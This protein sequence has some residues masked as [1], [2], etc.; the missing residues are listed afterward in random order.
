MSDQT[1]ITKIS[2]MKTPELIGILISSIVLC[3]LFI[4]ATR[5][6]SVVQS[7]DQAYFL[8]TIDTTYKTG[9]PTTRLQFSSLLYIHDLI[10][11]PAATVCAYPLEN[12]GQQSLNLYKRHSI[13]QLYVLGVIRRILPS[14]IIYY[15]CALLAFPGLLLVI[16][17]GSRYLRLPI[18]ISV[19]LSLMVA[20]HP[21]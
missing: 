4:N 9:H 8:E 20:F 12:D 14:K 3:F 2:Q 17:L 15:F 18:V 13:P 6:Y 19:I 5:F 10:V 7:L 21:A 11:A 1:R 16:Y